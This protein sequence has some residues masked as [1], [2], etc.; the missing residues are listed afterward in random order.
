[1]RGIKGALW[2]AGVALVFAT[3][4]QAGGVL[5]PGLY[6]G[7]MLAVDGGGAVSGSFAQQDSCAFRIA[8]RAS[9]KGVAEVRTVSEGSAPAIEGRLSAGTDSVSLALPGGQQLPG[10]GNVLPPLI[11]KGLDLDLTHKGTWT[12]LVSVVA[13]RTALRKSPGEAG[14]AYVVRGDVLGVVSGKADLLE[15]DFVS[16]QGRVM[17]GWIAAKDAKAIGAP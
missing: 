11:D 3:G 15:V 6:E 14:R 17:R 10:C 4:A 16:A 13:D 9:A 7:L 8:G 1:M 5:R 12:R 2:A